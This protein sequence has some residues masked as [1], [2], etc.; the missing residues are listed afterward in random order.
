MS[1]RL[2]HLPST[3]R[4]V[5]CADWAGT[6]DGRAA[7][8]ADVASRKV[9]RLT[10]RSLTIPTLLDEARRLS[11]S[12]KVLLGIDLPIGL[13][14]AYFTAARKHAGWAAVTAFI[15]WLPRACVVPDF[16]T[17]TNGSRWSV[18]QPFF[19]VPKGEGSLR[20]IQERIVSAGAQWKRAV[21]DLTSAKP[22]FV[23]SGIPG[24]VG[25]AVRDAWKDLGPMLAARRDFGVWPM[26]GD[27]HKAFD[28]RDVVI[29]EIYPRA[30]YATALTDGAASG[31][32]PIVIAKTR[33]GARDLAV[34]DLLG[35]DWVKRHS[36]ELHDSAEA[37]ENEDRFDAMITAAALLRCAIEGA[38]V[39]DLSLGDPA[40]EGSM[41]CTGTVNLA[42]PSRKHTRFGP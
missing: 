5:V 20:G 18:T 9:S 29:G 13:P 39:A 37:R 8:V 11:E 21:D 6:P 1:A 10:R 4:Y 14:A 24:A 30:A 25:S 15:D 23:V 36:V 2:D 12:G 34:D 27:L 26:E 38:P 16:F 22:M 35:Q 41:L 28:T 33:Q 42:L 19:A 17:P 31:R 32:C 7:Y 3:I 40:I